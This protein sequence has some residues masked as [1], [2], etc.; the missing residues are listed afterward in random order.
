MGE[1]DSNKSFEEILKE[2]QD[3]LLAEINEKVE[4]R[5]SG[6]NS[7]VNYNL[8]TFHGLDRKRGSEQYS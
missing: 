7:E 5:K 4:R 6:N 3:K 2:E 8:D 1:K